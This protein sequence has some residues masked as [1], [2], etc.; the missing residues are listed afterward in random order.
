MNWLLKLKLK[1]RTRMTSLW[2]LLTPLH[3]LLKLK[4]KLRTRVASLLS[5]WDEWGDDRDDREACHVS[6]V[7]A[8]PFHC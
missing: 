2:Q 3:W 5:A 1:L 7:H 4:L 6:Y 8:L